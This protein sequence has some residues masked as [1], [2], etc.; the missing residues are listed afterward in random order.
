M[1]PEHFF[2]GSKLLDS[3]TFSDINQIECKPYFGIQADNENLN[4]IEKATIAHGKL[5]NTLRQAETEYQ[6]HSARL[7]D[8]LNLANKPEE[9]ICTLYYE[10][11]EESLMRQ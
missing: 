3:I 4:L 2:F 8:F 6:L 5:T 11:A 9:L 7:T 1:A 10:K